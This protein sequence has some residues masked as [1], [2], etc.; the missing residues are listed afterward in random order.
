MVFELIELYKMM[1]ITNKLLVIQS[2]HAWKPIRELIFRLNSKGS[3]NYTLSMRLY[4]NFWSITW[5]SLHVVVIVLNYRKSASY[6]AQCVSVRGKLSITSGKSLKKSKFNFAKIAH[7]RTSLKL[8]GFHFGHSLY[9]RKN[10][11]DKPIKSIQILLK[12]LTEKIRFGKFVRWWLPLILELSFSCGK[13]LYIT[14]VFIFS[15]KLALFHQKVSFLRI[16]D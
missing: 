12:N 15:T 2:E 4:I 9:T 10:L 11:R 5:F 16:D 3:Q 6:R 7:F 1:L 8:R 14:W 13:R